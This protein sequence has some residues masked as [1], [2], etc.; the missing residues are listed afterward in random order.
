MSEENGGSFIRKRIMT[1]SEAVSLLTEKFPGVMKLVESPDELMIAAPFYAY[2]RFAS[3]VQSRIDDQAFL[4]S[5]GEFIDELASSND[6]LLENILAVTL[7]EKLAEN[8]SVIAAVK[9]HIGIQA[10]NLLSDVE[11]TLFGRI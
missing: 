4:R 3:H 8:P 9:P 1:A 7:L 5:V 2:E 11:R 10:S 6:P